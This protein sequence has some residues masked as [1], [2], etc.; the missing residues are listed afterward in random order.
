MGQAQR[1]Q[2][3]E[4]IPFERGPLPIYQESGPPDARVIGLT[5]RQC[6]Q[7]SHAKPGAYKENFGGPG[8]HL[9]FGSESKTLDDRFRSSSQAPGSSSQ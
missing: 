5:H 7:P 3:P 9:H 6:S 8:E 1:H 4:G 2:T